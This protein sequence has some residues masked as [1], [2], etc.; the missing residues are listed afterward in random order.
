[1]KRELKVVVQPKDGGEIKFYPATSVEKEG[2]FVTVK[3]GDK[4]AVC[5]DPKEYNFIV[6]AL[7]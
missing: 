5:F 1:M 3:D 4:M 6:R 2:A 7:T